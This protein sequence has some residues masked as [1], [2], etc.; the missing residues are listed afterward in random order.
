MIYS[1][2]QFYLKHPVLYFSTYP[3]LSFQVFGHK[4]PT[5]QAAVES[6]ST[7][8]DT[9]RYMVFFSTTHIMPLLVHMPTTKS[10]CNSKDQNMYGQL[11]QSID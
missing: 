4:I 5:F 6:L 9:A 10:S 8:P 3:F 2:C 7:K 1:S 11:K